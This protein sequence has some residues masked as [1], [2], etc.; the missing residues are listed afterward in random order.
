MSGMPDVTPELEQAK[1]RAE[2]RLL[3]LPGV[4][5]V[6]IGFKEVGG[7]PTDQLAIRVLV[8]EKKR[9]EEVPEE[10]RIP[11]EIEGHPSDV[12]Q[13]RFELHSTGAYAAVDEVLPAVD[14]GKYSP[15]RG[16]VS[17]GPCRAIGGFV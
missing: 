12:I 6:D 2:E 14:A 17:V 16:G 1:A 11:D 10:E 15:L 8:Q 7:E 3:G 13:R 4:T 9:L 5:G